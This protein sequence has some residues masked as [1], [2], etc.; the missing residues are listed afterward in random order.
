[1][2]IWGPIN[3][4]NGTKSRLSQFAISLWR[5]SLKSI[6]RPVTLSPKSIYLYTKMIYSSS[7]FRCCQDLS[8]RTF[9]SK[10]AILVPFGATR[11]HRCHFWG[12]RPNMSSKVASYVYLPPTTNISTLINSKKSGWTPPLKQNLKLKTTIVRAKSFCPLLYC[13]ARRL[14]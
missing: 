5:I 14:H 10:D 8:S 9:L 1:M 2:L 11:R 3:H 12:T 6:A 13:I 7:R 4:Q